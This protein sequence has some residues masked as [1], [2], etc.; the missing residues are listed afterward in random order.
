MSV[1]NFIHGGGPIL[2]VILA[3][4][5]IGLL[6]FFERLFVILKEKAELKILSVKVR[7]SIAQKNITGSKQHCRSSSSI[8]SAVMLKAFEYYEKQ[9]IHEFEST[10]QNFVEDETFKLEKNFRYI[11]MSISLS[12]LIGFFGTVVGMVQVFSGIQAVGGI[13]GLQGQASLAQGISVALYTTV[14]GLAVAITMAILM[15]VLREVEDRLLVNT[16]EEIR[17]SVEK[18]KAIPVEE[19][20]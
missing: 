6:F 12:P 7:N 15:T 4:G 10:I 1:G 17:T 5:V 11:S 20:H 14:G 3:L 13:S 19:V 16:I 2:F 8:F 9:R 18:L